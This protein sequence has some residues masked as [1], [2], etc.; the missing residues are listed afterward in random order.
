[1]LAAAA[2]ALWPLASAVCLVAAVGVI[3]IERYIPD[4]LRLIP[5]EEAAIAALAEPAPV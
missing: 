1:M 5:H 3:A 2:F 4:G